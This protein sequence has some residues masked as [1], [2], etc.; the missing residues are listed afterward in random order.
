MLPTANC[1]LRDPRHSN[2]DKQQTQVR[3]EHTGNTDVAIRKPSGLVLAAGVV[4]LLVEA[5]CHIL[6]NHVPGEHRRLK[7]YYCSGRRG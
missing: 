3:E 1:A 5:P 6:Q 4:R 7:S 2:Q